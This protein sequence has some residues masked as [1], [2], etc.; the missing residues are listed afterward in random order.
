MSVDHAVVGVDVTM[1]TEQHHRR[2]EEM[3]LVVQASVSDHSE[4]TLFS[5]PQDVGHGPVRF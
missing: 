1:V 5:H 3:L 2:S 4:D